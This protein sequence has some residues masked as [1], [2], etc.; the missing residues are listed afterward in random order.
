MRY[1]YRIYMQG[2]WLE[3]GELTFHFRPLYR[4]IA[5]ALHMLFGQS[6][7]GE[8]YWD[9]IGILI[10]ALFSF[11]VVRRL[12][13]FRWG[14]VAGAL[15]LTAYL[16][17]PGHVFIGRGLSEITS[18][19]FIYLAALFVI[20]ARESNTLRL[21]IAAGVCAVLGAWTRENNLAMALAVMVFALPLDVPASA[22][23]KPRE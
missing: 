19:A 23:W 16:S 14:I 11:E 21:L 7:T 4:W 15:T 22:M 17:G 20:A 10:I 2:Y 13:G 6:Q 8:N 12:R 1:A 9:A 3:G 5:G 18:A